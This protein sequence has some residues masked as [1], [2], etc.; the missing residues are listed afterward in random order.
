MKKLKEII[1]CEYDTLIKDI[2]IDSREVSDGDLFVAVN[3]FNVKH[4]DYIDDAISR[5]AAAV[6]TDID[7][8]ANIPIVKVSNVNKVLNDIC[9]KFYDY[10]NSQTLVGITG[11]DGKTTTASI[12]AQLL[13]EKY[14]TAYIGT[15]GIEYQNEVIKLENTTPTNEKLYKYLS[16]L[17]KNNCTHVVMEVSSEALLHERVND[18]AFKYAI[19]TNITEDHLNV[20]KTLENY[21]ESKLSLAKLVKR[22]GAIIVNIDDENCK[23]LTKFNYPNLYTYGKSEE[24]DF[25]ISNIK[26]V[27]NY[28]TFEIVVKNNVYKIKSPYLCEY[29]VYNVTAAFIVCYL[30]KLDLSSIISKIEVLPAVK[31]RTEF[32][33]FNQKYDLVLDYAHTLN[34][35]KNI[36]ESFKGKYKRIILLTGAAGGREQEKRSKI[37]KYILNNSDFVIFTMDDPRYESVDSIIDQM[38]GDEKKDNYVRIIDRSEA[39][40]YALDMARNGDIV[41]ILGKGRD[42]YMAI[43]NRREPYC[44]YDVISKYF[45]DSRNS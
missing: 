7:F 32:L 36:V 17:E 22:N 38:I 12:L 1:P 14:N 2:K 10:K 37:G 23:E 45:K 28:T 35:I 9:I 44:D 3:G 19:F 41:L 20:H 4:S 8:D 42:N 16:K 6:V 11:T 29:N 30:E 27:N 15:N 18:L 39:I 26:E 43:E 33:D 21:I 13:N 40:K 25:R 34:G 5:G 24:C 31:G